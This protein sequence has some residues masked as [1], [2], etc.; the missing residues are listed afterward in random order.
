MKY[1]S[2]KPLSAI[3]LGAIVLPIIGI[4]LGA[5]TDA[6]ARPKDGAPA[7][8]YR[9]KGN[10]N[11]DKNW[12][13]GDRDYDNDGVR[14]R[15]DRDD[16]NDGVRDRRDRDDD[17]DGRWDRRDRDDDND[18]VSDRR[19]RER[20]ERDRRNRDR[21][22][23]GIP[24]YRDNNYNNGNNG[25]NG[26]RVTFGA[27]V[28][29][30]TDS[31]RRFTVRADDNRTYRILAQTR[32]PRGLSV[33][34]RVRISGFVTGNARDGLFRADSVQIV[35]QG[36]GNNNGGN[37]GGG[38]RVNFVATVISNNNGIM[39]VRGDNG[40]TYRVRWHEVRVG[41]RVRIQGTVVNGIIQADSVN[42]A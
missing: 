34:D 32:E 23:D 37:Y 2:R 3:A 38:Q 28:T 13:H 7:H 19:E 14:N 11:K 21:D 31:D 9:N 42:Y 26:Q 36:N 20:R 27:I 15:R 25:N 41:G 10:K 39:R 4:S 22:N 29:R 6:Q 17:N 5:T 12:K 33:G 18:G 1:L 8:G 30:D 35:S 16:D 24:D 40:Q